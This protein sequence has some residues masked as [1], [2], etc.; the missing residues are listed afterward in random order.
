MRKNGVNRN[1]EAAVGRSEKIVVMNPMGYP[2]TIKQLGMA[3]RLD[4][5][6]GKTVYLVDVRFDDG[7]ILLQQMENWFTE[8]KPKVKTVFVRKSGVYTQDDTT[9]FQEIKEK[10]DAVILGVGH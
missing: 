7:D 8:H 6:D 10:A 5:L 3:P 4:S 2:P 1:Q 9:L